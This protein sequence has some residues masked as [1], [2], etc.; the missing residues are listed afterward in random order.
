MYVNFVNEEFSDSNPTIIIFLNK[1]RGNKITSGRIENI[2]T[3]IR[4]II[5][6]R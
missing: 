6:M 4:L 3:E 5:N 1:K 2:D